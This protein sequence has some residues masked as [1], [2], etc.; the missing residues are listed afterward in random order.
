MYATESL[1]ALYWIKNTQKFEKWIEGPGL[2]KQKEKRQPEDLSNDAETQDREIINT[3][4]I[5]VNCK[6]KT[7]WKSSACMLQ[8]MSLKD[9]CKE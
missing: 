7:A 6:Y 5:T 3:T 8:M 9:P 1:D 2:L 4:D